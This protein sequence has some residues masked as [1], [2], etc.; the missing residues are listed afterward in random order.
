[1]PLNPQA[2]APIWGCGGR[3]QLNEASH[4]RLQ[5]PHSA[6]ER[7]ADNGAELER[8]QRGGVWKK[9]W[10]TSLGRRWGGTPLSTPS[11]GESTWKRDRTAIQNCCRRGRFSESRAQIHRRAETED[12]EVRRWSATG[13]CTPLILKTGLWAALY[14]TQCQGKLLN[15]IST[16]TLLPLWGLTSWI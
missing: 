13:G 16:S 7:A 10:K 3:V 4:Q 14:W 9:F 1:M 15:Y 12:Q 11:A 5:E 2:I 6:D 8:D